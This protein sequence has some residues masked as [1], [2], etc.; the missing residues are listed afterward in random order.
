MSLTS[1]PGAFRL[2]R[3][4][5]APPE[6][7]ADTE[8]AAGA[9]RFACGLCAENRD[10]AEHAAV[11]LAR[12]HALLRTLRRM[13]PK[14]VKAEGPDDEPKALGAIAQAVYIATLRTRIDLY[15]GDGGQP[16]HE[17]KRSPKRL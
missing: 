13:E 12:A 16:A 11:Q 15:F 4:V 1:D 3:S 10:A 6:V 17:P 8:D 9:G 14:P 7:A 2:V 5:L